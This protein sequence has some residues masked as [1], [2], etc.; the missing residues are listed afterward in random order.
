MA[1]Q[2]GAALVPLLVLGEADS[3]RNMV[4]LPALQRWTYKRLG[5]PMPFVIVG[6]ARCLPLPAP[7]HLRWA[8]G[9]GGVGGLLERFHRALCT[10]W[11]AEGLRT[12]GARRGKVRIWWLAA[13]PQ[14]T[15]LLRPSHTH[16]SLHGA[17]SA[18]ARPRSVR[19]HL[20]RE[21]G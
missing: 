1:I 4:G 19:T 10:T 20:A 3:L 2:E 12:L 7:T 21:G 9:L 8:G 13:A 17:A 18:A 15:P 14:Q 6:R 5:F 16:A 11:G